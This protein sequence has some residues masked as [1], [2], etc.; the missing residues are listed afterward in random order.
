MVPHATTNLER[1]R[2][3]SNPTEPSTFKFPD[4]IQ[5][6]GE[7]REGD[8]FEDISRGPSPKPLPNGLPVGLHSSER[9]PM[10]KEANWRAWANGSAGVTKHGRQKSLS[11]AIRT[12]RTRNA[13]ISENAQEIAEALKAPVSYRLVVCTP[14]SYTPIYFANML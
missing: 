2:S 3:S 10:R 8:T 12:V 7:E 4:F 5:E 1:R 6:T 13:S 9:W 14:L 11:E